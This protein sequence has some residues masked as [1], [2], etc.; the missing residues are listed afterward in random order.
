MRL[1]ESINYRRH[2]GAGGTA[3]GEAPYAGGS[4]A[5]GV[6][7][8]QRSGAESWVRSGD[9]GT[10]PGPAAVLEQPLAEPPRRCRHSAR[11]RGSPGRHTARTGPPGL[12][13]QTRTAPCAVCFHTACLLLALRQRKTC[14]ECSKMS[15]RLVKNAVILRH[16]IYQTSWQ[17]D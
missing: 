10:R 6:G 12:R 8:G 17:S 2:A 16:V 5:R 4:G 14:G 3:A 9:R 13:P 1:G 7:R 15:I 11:R